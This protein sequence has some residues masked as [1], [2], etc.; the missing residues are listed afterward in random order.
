MKVIPR[1]LILFVMTAFAEHIVTGFRIPS[2]HPRYTIYFMMLLSGGIV[3]FTASTKILRNIVF[4]IL[5][6]IN[7][8]GL[9]ENYWGNTVAYRIPWSRIA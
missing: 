3:C 5:L 8:F 7:I 1:F 4:V 2:L 9:V 6:I